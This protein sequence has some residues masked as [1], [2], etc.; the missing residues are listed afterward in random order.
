MAHIRIYACPSNATMAAAHELPSP[1]ELTRS[2]EQIWSED[3]GRAQS[4]VNQAEMVGKSITAKQ[5]YAIKW[6]V[7][8]TDKDS[9]AQQK[10]NKIQDSLTRGFFKF[11]VSVNDSV[12]S[13]FAAYRSEIQYDIAQAGNEVYYKGVGVQVIEK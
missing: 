10:L 11:G 12:P 2:N 8:A 3:T 9:T 4:G 1:T 13:G 5:T 6:D 7:L